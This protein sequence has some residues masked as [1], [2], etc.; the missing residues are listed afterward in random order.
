MNSIAIVLLYLCW[1][2]LA[3]SVR[4]A[5]TMRGAADEAGKGGMELR[6]A[7]PGE[8]EIECPFMSAE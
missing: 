1:G 7:K 2:A 8:K 4:E 6:S 3:C 5:V